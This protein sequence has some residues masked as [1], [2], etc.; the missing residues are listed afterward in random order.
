MGKFSNLFWEA[1]VHLHISETNVHFPI[2]R[3]ICTLIYLAVKG[4]FTDVETEGTFTPL[5]GMYI[6]TLEGLTLNALL[7]HNAS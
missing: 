3:D 4:T 2:F 6:Y 5:G 1:N 7:Y